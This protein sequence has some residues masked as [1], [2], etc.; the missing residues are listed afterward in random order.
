MAQDTLWDAALVHVVGNITIENG[1]TLS[2][3]P[4][5]RVEFADYYRI[6]VAGTLLAI[7]TPE[8]RIVFTTD[9]PQDFTI[10][11]SQAGCWNGLRFDETS[12][13]NA[14]SQL[15]WC[16]LEY[17]KA[18]QGDARLY[19][20][21]GG[22]LSVCDFSKLVV[23]NCILRCN[24]ADYGGAVFLYRNANP[25]IRGNL[26][27][28]NHALQNASAIYCAY[29]H[30]VLANNTLVGNRIENIAFP[31]N[32]TCAILPFIAKPRL[33]NNIVRGNDPHVK[34]LHSQL[35]EAK[36]WYTTYND[37]EDY[38]PGN[39]NIDLDPLFVAP[40]AWESHGTPYWLD[41]TWI[42]GDERL[43]AGSPCIDAADTTASLPLL[44]LAGAPRRFDDAAAPDT[45]LGPPPVVDMGAYEF[46]GRAGD[47]NCDGQV[48]AFD[49]DAFVLAL[50]DPAGY[51]LA[52]P[53]CRRE[54]ADCNGDGAVDAFD[55]DPFIAL[56]TGA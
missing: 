35:W 4:G 31:Y 2:I 6:D 50:S 13:A 52:Y 27:V 20:L 46:A 12:S 8:Q 34:Y 38:P 25:V 7:G 32:E 41:D 24:V 26:I 43:A 39:G 22:A 45:G 48:N 49:I 16:I 23:E 15:A 19:P 42:A 36:A 14:T 29:S 56:L 33:V 1:V 18:T 5:V 55:I 37:I 30:P 3:T 9:D 28:A 44:D 11:G 51:A 54:L 17:S 53:A 47:L 10:D 40:G 21:G